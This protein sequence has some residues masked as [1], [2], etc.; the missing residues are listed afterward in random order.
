MKRFAGY[1]LLLAFGMGLCLA[2]VVTDD[3]AAAESERW[4]SED[5]LEVR[6]RA[7]GTAKCVIDWEVGGVGYEPYSV[8]AAGELGTV[9]LHPRGLLPEFFA[10]GYDDPFSPIQSV[11][12]LEEALD[13]GQGN[14]WSAVKY[15]W[16][17]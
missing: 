14:A 11:A 6:A 13:C 8:G 12:F 15:G 9:Q 1:S 10:A 16:C 17:G 3:V 4:T 2:V 5:V 7:S